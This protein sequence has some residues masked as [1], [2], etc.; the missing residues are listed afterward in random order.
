MTTY[1]MQEGTF[2]VPE[3]WRDQSMTVLRMPTSSKAKEAAIIVTRDYETPLTDVNEYADAQQKTAKE[4]FPGFK[5][6][7]REESTLAGQPAVI[8]DYQWRANGTVPLRQRQAYVRHEDVMLTLTVSAQA[9]EFG[10]IEDAWRRVLS[11][12][13][14]F[15]RD[16]PVQAVPGPLSEELPHVFALSARDRGLVVYADTPDACAKC[17]PFEVQDAGWIFFSSS[18]RPLKAIFE[19]ENRRG[20]FKQRPGRFVLQP[21]TA[22]VEPH[23]GTRLDR[24]TGIQGLAPFATVEDVAAHLDARHDVPGQETAS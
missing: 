10:G 24:V 15:T 9:N 6:L 17:D 21:D 1:H 23:L 19:I 12:L 11:T 14:L 20:V 4:S 18:G 7:G 8:V 22:G 2:S 3:G 5:A 13:N 16:E